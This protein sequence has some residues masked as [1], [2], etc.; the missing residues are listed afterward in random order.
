[1][2]LLVAHPAHSCGIGFRLLSSYSCSIRSNFTL[3]VSDGQPI[4]DSDMPPRMLIISALNSRN[5]VPCSGLVK[6]SANIFPVN[7][8]LTVI[9]PFLIWSLVKNLMLMY[10]VRFVLHS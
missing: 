3:E 4:S 8:F 5:M 2:N 1:M 10:F 9:S 7:N 6:W